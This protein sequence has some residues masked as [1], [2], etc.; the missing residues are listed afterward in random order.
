MGKKKNSSDA[1]RIGSYVFTL[2]E[3]R[4]GSWLVVNALSGHWSIRWR[5]DHMMY[6]VLGGLVADGKCHRYVDALMTMMYTAS[7]YPHDEV[8][9]VERQELPFINGFARLIQEEADFEVSV[10]GVAT[11]EEDAE[12]LA[13]TVEL[14]E[15]SD[16][17]E[18]LDGDEVH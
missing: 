4:N 9:I 11:D 12:A 18:R 14:Q 10:K 8:A 5:S 2:Q 17:L 3:N 16:E 1:V 7:S 13:G 15:I 6:A